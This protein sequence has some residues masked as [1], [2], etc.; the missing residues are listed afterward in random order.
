[1][2]TYT[3][4]LAAHFV[5]TVFQF[6][7]KQNPRRRIIITKRKPHHCLSN[8]FSIYPRRVKAHILILH[9]IIHTHIHTIYTYIKHMYT[10]R[11]SSVNHPSSPG[12]IKTLYGHRLRYMMSFTGIT[13]GNLS[14]RLHST[15]FSFSRCVAVL[16]THAR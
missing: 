7:R 1:M 14:I 3:A 8:P 9:I 16:K 10:I 13:N 2:Y 4:C 6:V 5:T 12:N 15:L 11:C